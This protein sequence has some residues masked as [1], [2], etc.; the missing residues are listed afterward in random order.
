MIFGTV[1]SRFCVLEALSTL[2]FVKSFGATASPSTTGRLVIRS[3][4][5]ASVSERIDSFRA[6]QSDLCGNSASFA[7]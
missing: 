6:C 3:T 5:I 1:N 4:L 7:S 2:Q